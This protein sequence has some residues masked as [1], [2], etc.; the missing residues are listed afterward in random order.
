MGQFVLR[1]GPV[2]CGHQPT[3]R[4]WPDCKFRYITG[5]RGWR[6]SPK[7]QAEAVEEADGVLA[8]AGSKVPLSSE[9]RRPS[10]PTADVITHYFAPPARVNSIFDIGFIRSVRHQVFDHWWGG[11]I[12][13]SDLFLSRRRWPRARWRGE[14][15]RINSSTSLPR[16]HQRHRAAGDSCLH[17]AGHLVFRAC[18][19]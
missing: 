12:S 4:M 19:K 5:R 10:M 14:G 16:H 3:K 18:W 15:I 1:S 13:I 6:W 11:Q 2:V 17:S 9:R 8:H 7:I